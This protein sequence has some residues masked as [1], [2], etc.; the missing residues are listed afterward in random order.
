MAQDLNGR[1][2]AVTGAASGIGFEC[3]KHMIGAGITVFLVDRD[4]NAL[5]EKCVELGDKA[6]PLVVDLLDP[7]SV[8]TM[9]P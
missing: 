9:M 3:A 7:A 5:A 6:K 8:A 4:E 1:V 2:A